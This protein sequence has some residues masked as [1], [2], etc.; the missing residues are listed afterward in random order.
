MEVI[1]AITSVMA[2]VQI[3]SRLIRSVNGHLLREELGWF[4]KLL[5]SL[6]RTLGELSISFQESRPNKTSGL[7]QSMKDLRNAVDRGKVVVEEVLSKKNVKVFVFVS[8]YRKKIESVGL[9]IER[10][11]NGIQNS[12][13]VI[14]VQLGESMKK[15]H[16]LT[17]ELY[18]NV[19][20][21]LVGMEENQQD[22]LKRFDD[23][24]A[25][26]RLVIDNEFAKDE[27]DVGNQL[28]S[29]AQAGDVIRNEKEFVDKV[30]LQK[31]IESSKHISSSSNGYD[32]LL[33]CPLSLELMEDPVLINDHTYDRKHLCKS[34]LLYPNLDP[35]TNTR[36]DERASYSDNVAIRKLLMKEK[37]DSAY[38]KYDD[39]YFAEAYEKAWNNNMSGMFPK[40]P[41]PGERMNDYYQKIDEYLYGMNR[42]K[43][44][45]E[46]AYK[47]IIN[48]QDFESNPVMNFWKARF[49]DPQV[50]FYESITFE[51]NGKRANELYQKALNLDI[52]RIAVGGDPYAHA[53]LGVMY[54]YG[55]C[56]DQSYSTAVECY[57]K[58][59]EQG[60]S[61]GQHNLGWMYQNGYGVDQSY[62]TAVEWYRKAAEQG[63]AIAQF[64][65]GWMY[66]NGYG[67][68][69]NNSTA[70]EWYRKAA[71]Q[72]HADAQISLGV[73]Y[74]FGWGVNKDY[75]AAADCYRKVAEQMHKRDL[76]I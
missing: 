64:N 72:G 3:T 22:I 45:V 52:E 26:L 46:K 11:L 20:Q 21:V 39:S 61:R 34:L 57:R 18:D 15:T 48:A 50:S 62:S 19:R 23:M 75:N 76:T 42:R 66:Q 51:K 8:S 55:C 10:A 44:D 38:K 5:I 71:E 13:V 4:E 54:D 53:C 12:G 14:T 41:A 27:E 43:I 35:V 1:G 32:D 16:D 37:G 59:A 33:T 2:L 68:D 31:V 65:L 25:L 70:V 69:K 6:E 30:I 49:A 47:M 63:N 24:E 7:V 58:A 36:F 9:E 28:L 17:V 29:I 60:Y 67:V 74:E 73:M 40:P 56:V